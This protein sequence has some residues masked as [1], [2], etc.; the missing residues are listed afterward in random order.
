MVNRHAVSS[1]LGFWALSCIPSATAATIWNVCSTNATGVT[2]CNTNVSPS[3]GAQAAVACVVLL[4]LLLSLTAC[5]MCN[6]RAAASE[7]YNVEASQ[8]HGPPTIIATEYHP[9]SG[10]SGVYGGPRSSFRNGQTGPQMTGPAY[11]VAAQVSK[12]QT[13]T[14]PVTQCTFPNPPPGY[15]PHVAQTAFVN[16]EFPRAV[17]AGDRLKGKLKDRPAT[18]SHLG[19]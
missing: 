13:R 14:A 2:T 15:S 12:N 5:F 19:N 3:Y 9:T 17:L 4:L 8:V 10:P 18:A 11:P 7:V 6:R 1:A 16:G